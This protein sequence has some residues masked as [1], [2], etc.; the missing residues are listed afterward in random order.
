MPGSKK[1][2]LATCD[3]R[4]LLIDPDTSEVRLRFTYSRHVNAEI[5]LQDWLSVAQEKCT[6][7]YKPSCTYGHVRRL[8]HSA[9]F[10]QVAS[11]I[12]GPK[13]RGALSLGDQSETHTAAEQLFALVSDVVV[14]PDGAWAALA[15]HQRVEAFDLKVGKH[16]GHLPVFEVRSIAVQVHL[17][18][19]QAASW[20]R[21]REAP[22]RDH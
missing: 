10:V 2:L 14:S 4:V 15:L 5:N 8:E 3:A 17:S 19:A 21:Q 11:S 7:L 6:A 13:R 20:R 12:P 22:W 18:Q 1:L 9:C 16:H